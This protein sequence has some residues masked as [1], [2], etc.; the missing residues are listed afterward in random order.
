[1]KIVGSNEV[2]NVQHYTKRVGEVPV[3]IFIRKPT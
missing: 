1:M 3:R 2:S